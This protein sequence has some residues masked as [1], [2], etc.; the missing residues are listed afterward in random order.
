MTIGE[1]LLI[2]RRKTALTH[3]Q[4]GAKI[5]VH[6]NTI[7]LYETGKSM[8]KIDVV[9]ALCGVY[10]IELDALFEGVHY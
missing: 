8:P 9:M 6:R 3:K 4:V 5:G 1:S 7:H 10:D 2:A